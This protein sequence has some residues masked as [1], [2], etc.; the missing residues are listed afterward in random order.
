MK[1][2]VYEGQNL[3][4]VIDFSLIAAVNDFGILFS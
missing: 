1:Y 2:T 3:E 4:T